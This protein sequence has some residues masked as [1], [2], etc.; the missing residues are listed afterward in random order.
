MKNVTN[1]ANPIV[2]HLPPSANPDDEWDELERR[3]EVLKTMRFDKLL[4]Q[5]SSFCALLDEVD[6]NIVAIFG[7]GSEANKQIVLAT[8]RRAGGKGA[9]LAELRR[10]L[11][12]PNHLNKAREAL[13]EPK[14]ENGQ[15]LPPLTR[16]DRGENNE[17][18]IFLA[19]AP[20]EV[21]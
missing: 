3:R 9:S 11:P 19:E 15:K 14:D 21:K 7:D 18:R 1:S 12:D 10:L 4:D 2:E 16:E 6:A 20:E 17:L 13:F 5:H 8:A